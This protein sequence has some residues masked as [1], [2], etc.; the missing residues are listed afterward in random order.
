MPLN[1]VLVHDTGRER[2]LGHAPAV[3]FVLHGAGGDKT[4]NVH[5]DQQTMSRKEASIN[6]ERIF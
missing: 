5:L 4:V 1:L 6:N 2:K 3:D